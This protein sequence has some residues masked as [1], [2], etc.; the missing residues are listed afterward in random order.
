[1]QR[2]KARGRRSQL[3]SPHGFSEMDGDVFAAANTRPHRTKAKQ[4]CCSTPSKCQGAE[5]KG[6]AARNVGL[7]AP[8]SLRAEPSLLNERKY[9]EFSFGLGI[10]RS[11]YV[12]HPCFNAQH[13]KGHLPNIGRLSRCQR[14]I[15][16]W[17]KKSQS[18]YVHVSKI[19]QHTAS[20][21]IRMKNPHERVAL[22]YTFSR[23]I[24]R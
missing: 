21:Y 10:D 13:L 17:M 24:G 1:M 14:K 8:F 12:W 19:R 3:R 16:C 9:H 5:R 18:V 6:G 2:R 23:C 7:R 15:V 4:Y 22:S 20:S 11:S